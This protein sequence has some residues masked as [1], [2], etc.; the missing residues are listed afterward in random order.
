M[1]IKRLNRTE[2]NNTIA[3]PARACRFQPASNFPADDTGYGFDSNILAMC[4]IGLAPSMAEKYLSAAE[5]EIDAALASEP[6]EPKSV[7][8]TAGN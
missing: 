3:A 6:P 5:D 1:T 7:R 4:F 8:R 2:Y